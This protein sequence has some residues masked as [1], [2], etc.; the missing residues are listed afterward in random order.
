LSDYG[1]TVEGTA[2]SGDTIIISYTAKISKFVSD[3]TYTDYGF[4][5]TVNLIGVTNGMVP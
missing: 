3:A 2:A 5:A 4:K 1:I